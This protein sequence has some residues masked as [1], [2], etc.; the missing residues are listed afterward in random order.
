MSQDRGDVS[1]AKNACCVFGILAFKYIFFVFFSTIVFRLQKK[2]L[3]EGMNSQKLFYSLKTRYF[4]VEKLVL[5]V[6]I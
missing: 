3:Y 6:G 4:I 5:V 1:K 2:I